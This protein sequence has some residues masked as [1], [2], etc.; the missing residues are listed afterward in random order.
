[1]IIGDVPFSEKSSGEQLRI[2]TRIGM[3]LNPELRVLFIED[4]SLLDEESYATIRELAD[5]HG[6]QILVENV[7]ES[8]GDDQIVMRAGAVISKF[9]HQDTTREKAERMRTEL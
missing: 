6:Y 4:G 3:E 9:E 1:M 2:S 7:G 8:P 5:R